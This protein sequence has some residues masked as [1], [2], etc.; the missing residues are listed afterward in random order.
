VN[1]LSKTGDY[2]ES[3]VGTVKSAFD[4]RDFC[5]FGGLFCIGYGLYLFRP[6]LGFS[7][8]G[9]VSMLLGL[10]WLVRRPK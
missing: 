7:V 4:I 9:A 2:L 6:W 10:G 1:I 8:F 5:V 3:W